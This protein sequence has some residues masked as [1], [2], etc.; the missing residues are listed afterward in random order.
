MSLIDDLRSIVRSG[1]FAPEDV[2]HA[3]PL[4]LFTHGSRADVEALMRDV[5]AVD[6]VLTAFVEGLDRTLALEDAIRAAYMERPIAHGLWKALEQAFRGSLLE[7]V[8]DDRGARAL[9]DGPRRPPPRPEP[10]TIGR[11]RRARRAPGSPETDL[12]VPRG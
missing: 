8:A 4:F 10:F 7:G 6:R 5:P 9:I 2:L 11:P 3:M 12:H 1:A